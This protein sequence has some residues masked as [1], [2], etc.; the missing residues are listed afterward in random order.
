MVLPSGNPIANVLTSTPLLEIVLFV[1][2]FAIVYGVL[3][4]V[5]PFKIKGEEANRLEWT[6][7]VIAFAVSL[8][9]VAELM[10]TRTLTGLGGLGLLSTPMG[11]IPLYL[12]T[13]I[14]ILFF[15]T[16]VSLFIDAIPEEFRESIVGKFVFLVVYIIF[17][18]VI[19]A[20]IIAILS[21][22]DI[23]R[24]LS[25]L[26]SGSFYRYLPALMNVGLVGL[27]LGVFIAAIYEGGESIC[28]L[29]KI[30]K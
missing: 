18:I 23:A 15:S 17:G 26:F 10:L 5:D 7:Y 30:C 28:R 20:T 16:A 25:L 19:I 29:L 11:L 6:Y 1:L 14:I 13:L 22:Q 21:G 27:I 12:L 2:Y 9:G 4:R 3:S 24:I 8:I